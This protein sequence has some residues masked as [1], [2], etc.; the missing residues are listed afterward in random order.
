MK[1]IKIVLIALGLIGFFGVNI[2]TLISDESIDRLLLLEGVEAL[3]DDEVI[4]GNDSK[5]YHLLSISCGSLDDAIE[6]PDDF[7]SWFDQMCKDLDY[8]EWTKCNFKELMDDFQKEI[9]YG[10]AGAKIVDA[11][12]Y[13]GYSTAPCDP[14]YDNTYCN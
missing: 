12:L 13:L 11:C 10:E 2:H 8:P 14:A 5:K 6:N 7:Q 4:I 1:K 9:E 3:A